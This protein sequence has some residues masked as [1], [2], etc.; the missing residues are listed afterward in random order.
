VAPTFQVTK[1]VSDQPTAGASTTDT[2]LV[3]PWGLAYGPTTDFWISNQATSTAT[4][5]DGLGAR[6]TAPIT[7]SVPEMA[8]HTMVG[9]TGMVFNGT[10]GFQA[11]EFI[12]A[13]LDGCICGWSTGTTMTRRVDNSSSQAVY[14]GLALGSDGTTTRLYAAN[15]MAGTVDVFDTAYAPVLLGASAFVDPT[16]PSGFSPYNVQVLAGNVYLTYA[17]HAPAALRETTGAGLGYVSQ[18]TH[19]GTF[20]KRIA[21]AG[22]LNAPWGL[23]MAPSAFGSFSGALLVGNFGDG[24]ITAFNPTTGALIGQIP[25]ATGAPLAVPGL[26]GMTVGNGVAAGKTTQLYVT[27]GSQ[28]ETHGLFATISYGASGTGT[29]GG[30]YGGGLGY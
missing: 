16:L 27:A 20:V 22:Q 24:H 11:D 19:D 1:L 23:A 8:G 29:G 6:P 7:V 10:T 13:S 4:V 21:S 14:T 12:I 9:P 28:A 15:L 17:Q 3:N 25:D 26:W 2:S 30:G 5:Y 18:F